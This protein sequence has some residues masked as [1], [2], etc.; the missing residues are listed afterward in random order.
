MIQMARVECDCYA[1]TR[2]PAVAVFVDGRL[3]STCA[4]GCVVLDADHTAR[5]FR[6]IAGG[7]VGQDDSEAKDAEEDGSGKD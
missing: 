7:F 5:D 3:V 4:D 1:E 2:V 6:P